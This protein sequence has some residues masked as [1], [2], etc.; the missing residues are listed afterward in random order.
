MDTSKLLATID[1]C[2]ALILRH[3]PKAVSQHL[4]MASEEENQ[5]CHFR[6]MLGM[7]RSFAS[8]GRLDRAYQ[9]MGFVQGALCQAKHT[10]IQELQLI[11]ILGHLP[12]L[13]C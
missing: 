4:P 7:C 6:W 9:W 5:M 11:D 3:C 2:D 10:T 8:R 1:A 13:D 12:D